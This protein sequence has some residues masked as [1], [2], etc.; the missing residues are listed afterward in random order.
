MT[1]VTYDGLREL[2]DNGKL[3]PG[4]KYRMIDYETTTSQE[5]TQA[6]GHPFDLILTALDEKT[7]DEKCSAIQSARDTEGYF[8]NSDLA[9]WQV[10]YTLDNDIKYSWAVPKGLRIGVD[11]SEWDEGVLNCFYADTFI[12]NGEQYHKWV[13]PYWGNYCYV[14][15]K[16]KTPNIGE[17]T[18]YVDIVNGEIDYEEEV[19][20]VSSVSELDGGK[21]VIYR[22]IDE[23]RNDLPYDFKNIMYIKPLDEYGNYDKEN[24]V[25]HPVYTFNQFINNESGD[26][27]LYNSAVYSNVMTDCGDILPENAIL[28]SYFCFVYNNTFISSISNIFDGNT[29]NNTFIDSISNIF[30]RDVSNNTFISCENNKIVGYYTV[31]NYFNQCDNNTFYG[32]PPCGNKF[33]FMQN[34]SIYGSIGGSNIASAENFICYFNLVNVNVRG[35]ICNTKFGESYQQETGLYETDIYGQ[36]NEL[37]LLF[38]SNNVPYIKFCGMINYKSNSTNNSSKEIKINGFDYFSNIPRGYIYL[39]ANDN[40]IQYNDLDIYNAINK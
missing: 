35:A 37:T 28:S 14:L 11:F 9:A 13:I 16:T 15:T 21:G 1:K 3:V 12:Y 40:V 27:S 2:R 7:L 34:C 26:L 20:F 24:G 18:I 22:M 25:K 31:N 6:A 33:N 19:G 32:D 4:C 17:N 30:G 36:L 39:D 10:W 23:N 5:G 29:Y 8:A 38:I